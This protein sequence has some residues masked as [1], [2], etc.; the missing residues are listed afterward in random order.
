MSKLLSQIEELARPIVE[1]K[2]AFLIDVAVRG[3]R[4]T[5][6]IEIFVDT[7]QGVTTELCSEISRE[8]SRMLDSNSIVYGSYYLVV[9]SPGI[10][11]P[12]KFFRQ[13][14]KNIGRKMIVKYRLNEHIERIEG[15]LLSAETEQIVLRLQNDEQ[16]NILFSEIVEAR[17]IAAW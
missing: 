3:E 8:I 4:K 9:S 16:R 14:S 15:E 6:V 7:E 12:L 5:K 17:V 10:E 2:N 1:A 11:C 13:Y